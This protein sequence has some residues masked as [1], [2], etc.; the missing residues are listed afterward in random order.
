MT[1]HA[2]PLAARSLTAS[3]GPT[4]Q[5]EEFSAAQVEEGSRGPLDQHG[6]PP[7]STIVATA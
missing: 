5:R 3:P 2:V 6:V 1:V 7:L 4:Q